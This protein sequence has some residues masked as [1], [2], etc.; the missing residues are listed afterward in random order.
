MHGRSGLLAIAAAAMCSRDYLKTFEANCREQRRL[1]AARIL[2][3]C[4]T[5][6]AE[7]KYTSTAPASVS[8]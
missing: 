4:R 7:Q 5:P 8:I 3:P 1:F 6:G 2:P